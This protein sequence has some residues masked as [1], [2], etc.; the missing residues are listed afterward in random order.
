M[1]GAEPAAEESSSSDSDDEEHEEVKHPEG[2]EHGKEHEERHYRKKCHRGH[3]HHH[4]GGKKRFGKMMRHVRSLIDE[5]APQAYEA[6]RSSLNEVP[7]ST[8]D[9]VHE[10]FVCDGCEMNPIVGVR[11]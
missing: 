1:K 2:H 3:H 4:C 9:P 5:F 10:N 6:V 8:T 11:Y 7:A